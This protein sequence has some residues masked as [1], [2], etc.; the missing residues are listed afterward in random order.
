M[1]EE[2]C[3]QSGIDPKTHAQLR[4]S[5]S[6]GRERS[7]G[8]VLPTE[9]YRSQDPRPAQG[10]CLTGEEGECGKSVANR[11]VSIPRPTPSSG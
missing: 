2:C 3:Q 1:W 5:A 10:E 9:R 7:V 4:V 11:A 8:R 6:Q